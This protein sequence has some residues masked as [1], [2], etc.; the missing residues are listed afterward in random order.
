MRIRSLAKGDVGADVKWLKSWLNVFVT[1]APDLNSDNKFDDATTRAI[2]QFKLQ[3]GILPMNGV[4]DSHVY[5][6]IWQKIS[7]TIGNTTIF[8]SSLRF[9]RTIFL[10]HFLQGFTEVKD[11]TIPSLLRFLSKIEWDEGFQSEHVPWVAYMLATTWWETAAT[12]APVAEG[13]CDDTGCTPVT[14]KKT[15]AVNNRT[16]GRP[17]ACPNPAKCP[18]Q[19][20]PADPTNAAKTHT[21]YG[22]GYVQLTHFDT[23]VSTSR[24]L[25][26]EGVLTAEDQLVHFP[27]KVMDEDIAYL[28]ISVGLREG[29]FFTTQ[30]L[31]Q[32]IDLAHPATA[33][34]RL[35]Q[36]KKRER[37]STARITMMTLPLWPSNLRGLSICRERRLHIGARLWRPPLRSA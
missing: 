32:F 18:P 33:A 16:Y 26:R 5:T 28:I 3:N 34:Q 22:R 4:A 2:M 6:V 11:G 23:Y 27:E 37:L 21:Y 1:P 25:F 10:D 29:K 31:S 20:C 17:R 7:P 12:F 14:N 35:T 13:G 36:Y 15:G 19:P 30:K 8:G 24:L 9:D